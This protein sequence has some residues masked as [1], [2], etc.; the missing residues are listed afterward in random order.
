[1]KDV[2]LSSRSAILIAL[3]DFEKEFGCTLWCE[4]RTTNIA[5]LGLILLDISLG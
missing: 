4:G 3:I 2:L 1:M 5:S